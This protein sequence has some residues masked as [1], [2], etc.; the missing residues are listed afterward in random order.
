MLTNIC[1]PVTNIWLPCKVMMNVK[2][3]LFDIKVDETKLNEAKSN[4]TKVIQKAFNN[5][6]IYKEELNVIDPKDS[7]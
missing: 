4:L 1:K 5:R 6:I 7:N 3:N 2:T